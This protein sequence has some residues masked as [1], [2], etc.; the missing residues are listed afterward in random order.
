MTNMEL[1]KAIRAD[2]K[3]AGIPKSAYSISVKYAGYE[4]SV[5]VRVKDLSI[6]M[7]RF[8]NVLRRYRHVDWDDRC[9]EILAGGNTFV[10]ADYDINVLCDASARCRDRAAEIMA[11]DLPLF[12]GVDVAEFSRNGHDYV[13]TY[14]KGD[15]EVRAHKKGSASWT[16]DRHWAGNVSGMAEALAIFN[17]NGSVA[18]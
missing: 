6:N 7:H 15:N 5:S 13:L 17:A 10:H 14:F 9:M 16:G 4:T 11:M 8:D 18:R 3:A 2:L 1:S 12:V